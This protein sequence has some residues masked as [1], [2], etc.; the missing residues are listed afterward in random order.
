M[1]PLFVGQRQNFEDGA[2]QT[3]I[4]DDPSECGVLVDDYNYREERDSG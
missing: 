3:Y 2:Y 1:K 4:R